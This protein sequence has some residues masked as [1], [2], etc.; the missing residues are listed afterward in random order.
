MLHAL[1]CHHL[2]GQKLA[3]CSSQHSSMPEQVSLTF[4]VIWSRA[5][6]NLWAAYLDYSQSHECISLV[7]APVYCL[8]SVEPANS[9]FSITTAGLL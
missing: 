1:V 2:P 3:A 4:A 5:L 6:C 9:T 7:L 8:H